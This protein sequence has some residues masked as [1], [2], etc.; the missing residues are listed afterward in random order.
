MNP[1]EKAAIQEET[2]MAAVFRSIRVNASMRNRINHEN[3]PTLYKLYHI[4]LRI[5]DLD[6]LYKKVDNFS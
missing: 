5:C 1:N 4:I 3:A 2:C 6:Q